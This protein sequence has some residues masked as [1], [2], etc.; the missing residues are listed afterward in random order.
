[1]L[2]LL[3]KLFILC[4]SELMFINAN[5]VRSI[6]NYISLHKYW[7]VIIGRLYDSFPY[8]VSNDLHHGLP[9]PCWQYLLSCI[10]RHFDP[11]DSGV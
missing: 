8:G 1:M 3:G 10:V 4:R 9:Y 11:I 6:S 2:V 5:Q 7:H